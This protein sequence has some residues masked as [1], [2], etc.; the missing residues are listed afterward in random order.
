MEKRRHGT[1]GWI[2]SGSA[3]RFSPPKD[4]KCPIC[5]APEHQRLRSWSEDLVVVIFKCGFSA[6]FKASTPET[7]KQKLLEKAKADGAI[8]RWLRKPLFFEVLGER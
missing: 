3:L 5:Q 4:L 8:E 2:S 1:A 6:S 7:E